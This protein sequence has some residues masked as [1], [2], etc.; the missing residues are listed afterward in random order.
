MRVRCDGKDVS[1][2]AVEF[3]V[4]SALIESKGRVISRDR[5]MTLARGRDYEAFDRSIDVHVS[6]IRKKIE[7]DPGRPE[8]IKTV[9]GKG[10]MWCDF[11]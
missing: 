7:V 11:Q 2:S 8:R 1:L 10:Y 3:D 9:W 4:L 5:L 6:R